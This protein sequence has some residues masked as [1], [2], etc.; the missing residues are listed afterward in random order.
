MLVSLR[1]R[2]FALIENGNIE[3]GKGLNVLSGETGAGKSILVRAIELLAGGRG[4]SDLIRQGEEEA[5]VA[6]LFEGVLGEEI[7]LRR[8]VTQSGKSRS[9]LNERPVPLSVLEEEGE[10]LLDIAGQHEHQ[11]LLRPERHLALLDQFAGLEAR[12]RCFEEKVKSYLDLC[13]ETDLLREREREIRERE[14][15]LRFQLKEIREAEIQPGEEERLLQER[16]IQRHSVRL[17]QVSAQAETVLESGEDSVTE[18]LGRVSREVQAEGR[19]DPELARIGESLE[20]ILCRTQDL[21]RTL[22]QKQS[23]LSSDPGRLQEIEDRLFLISRLKKKYGGTATLSVKADEIAEGLQFL[24]HF[25]EEIHKKEESLSLFGKG[26][27]GLARDLSRERRGATA[28]LSHEVSRELKDLEMVSCRF[29]VE[30][31]PLAEGM[32]RVQDMVLGSQG[33]DEAEFLIA[34]NPGEGLRP[35]IRIASGGELSRIFLALKKVLAGRREV[36]DRE[37]TLIFDEVDSGI[38]GRVAEVVGRNLGEL[39]KKRQVVCITHLPQIACFADSHFVIEKRTTRG[40]TETQV[41]L[42]EGRERE[43]EI[44]RMLAGVEV[45][46]QARAHAREMLKNATARAS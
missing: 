26:L 13:R 17:S 5:E 29:Q 30:I 2:N 20:E 27:V 12:V 14:E 18:R 15:F 11:I 33:T 6:A 16:E 40:R 36:T 35:L 43:D 46:A 38:G 21:A 34:P 8:V 4:S 9:Y 22:R 10:T 45:T 7:S 1:I 44:A 31:Q 37:P 23:S 25:D 3:F 42:L 24:D 19:I 39:A 41:L 28:R 32:V